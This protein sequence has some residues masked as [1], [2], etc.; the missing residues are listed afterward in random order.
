[1]VEQN[2]I[3]VQETE[4]LGKRIIMYKGEKIN[5]EIQ[6]HI[7]NLKTSLASC[8][9]RLDIAYQRNNYHAI[10]EEAEK[11]SKLSYAITY[12]EINCKTE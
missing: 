1:M 11:I 7:N 2:L 6:N 10:T 5:M 3:V 4:I 8:K 9:R 12:L